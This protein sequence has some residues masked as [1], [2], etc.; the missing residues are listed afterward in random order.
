MLL[1]A[2][3]LQT[4][5]VV[6]NPTVAS[7]RERSSRYPENA[8]GSRR[9]R[10]ETRANPLKA[11]DPPRAHVRWVRPELVAQSEF[12]EWTAGGK[13]RHASF[14]GLRDDKDARAVRQEQPDRAPP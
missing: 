14:R 2:Q 3:H 6:T 12:Q 5:A 1:L 13:I 8:S 10:L 4:Q 9:W 7:P 11:G